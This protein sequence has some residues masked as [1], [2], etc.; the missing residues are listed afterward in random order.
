VPIDALGLLI[1]SRLYA[2][3]TIPM[4][5]LAIG[6]K[7]ILGKGVS[8]FFHELEVVGEIVNRVELGAQDFIRLLQMI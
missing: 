2:A 5:F 1:L 7:S 4:E 6:T 8:H 3:L